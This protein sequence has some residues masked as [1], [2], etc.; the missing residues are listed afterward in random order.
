M[1]EQIFAVAGEKLK[2]DGVMYKIY[3]AGVRNNVPYAAVE[4]ANQV[5]VDTIIKYI[6]KSMPLCFSLEEV[7][8]ELTS[9]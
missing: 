5:V 1:L 9:P 8:K 6:R 2:Y 4:P 7:Q 3:E